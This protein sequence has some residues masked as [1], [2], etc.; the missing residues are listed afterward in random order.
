M[1]M[2]LKQPVTTAVRIGCSGFV[3]RLRYASFSLDIH[4][5]LC[6]QS[7]SLMVFS[8]SLSL[9]THCSTES[10]QNCQHGKPPALSC[11]LPD[12]GF[13]IQSLESPRGH[14]EQATQNLLSYLSDHK[15]VA[16]QWIPAL[17]G[18]SGKEEARSGILH[19]IA[20]K[21]V[22]TTHHQTTRC[23]V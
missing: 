2:W 5:S 12:C 10:C 20:G 6:L 23:S 17:C 15:M 22:N 11:R 8:D 1:V 13:I 19:Y 4:L 14:L 18:L 16:V 21:Q 3:S 9:Y 7:R